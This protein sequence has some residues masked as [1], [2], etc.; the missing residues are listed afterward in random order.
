MR[1]DPADYDDDGDGS[2]LI[3]VEPV[4]RLDFVMW[5]VAAGIIVATAILTWEMYHSDCECDEAEI[6]EPIQLPAGEHSVVT[7]RTQ[8]FHIEGQQ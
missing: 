6:V 2:D 4:F 7:K 8:H 1:D 5:C 3:P